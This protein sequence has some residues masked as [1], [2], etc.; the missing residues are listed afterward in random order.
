MS[1]IHTHYRYSHILDAVNTSNY[2]HY[3]ILSSNLV[4]LRKL[5]NAIATAMYVVI[6]ILGVGIVTVIPLYIW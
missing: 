2:N 5:F 4:L 3:C 1:V 6:T